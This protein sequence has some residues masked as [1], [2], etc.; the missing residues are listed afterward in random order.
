MPSNYEKVKA[1]RAAN[2]EKRAD[3]SRRY[4]ERHPE[5]NRKA[6]AKYREKNI[7][8][9]RSSDREAAANRRRSDPEGQ[10][11]RNEE[12]R[13]RQEAI[14]IEIAG[15]P[16]PDLCELCGEFHQRIVWDH[17][18]ASGS[19]RG[20][21][22]DRCNKVLGLV[23]DRPSILKRLARYLEDHHVEADN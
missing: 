21:L 23:Y 10:R 13:L 16:K 22:C 3:Q 15:R 8:A 20:W 4:A 19:F 17:C 12:Y 2:P 7:D 14:R 11:R 9:I 1:W 18:H 5:T 6:K